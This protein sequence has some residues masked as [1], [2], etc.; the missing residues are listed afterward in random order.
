MN[1]QDYNVLIVDDDLSFSESLKEAIT[2]SGFR[3][4]CVN[5]P[6]D[7][8]EYSKI[9]DIHAA[10]IDCLLP[11]INGLDLVKDLQK[12]F[13]GDPH[14][15]LMSGIFK[16][17]QFI[18]ESMKNIGAKDFLIK[19]FNVRK[20]TKTLQLLFTGLE[21]T[22]D[23]FSP[24]VHLYLQRI[25]N[26][27]ELIKL[28]NNSKGL[29][30]FDLPW[31]FKLIVD[32]NI[33]GHLSIHLTNGHKASVGFSQGEIVKVNI[34][35]KDSLLGLLL[36]EK[37]YLDREDLDKVVS[38]HTDN[39]MIGRHLIEENLV[40]PH[41]ISIVLKDQLVWRLKQLMDKSQMEL[42]FEEAQTITTITTIEK[43]EFTNFLLD[44]IKNT[45]SPSWLKTHY[46]P[47]S[48]KMI[49]IN[50]DSNDE[51]EK[52]L[53]FPYVSGFYPSISPFLNRGTTLE[54]LLS[55]N[56]DIEDHVLK[57]IHFL[58]IMGCINIKNNQ[59]HLNFIHQTKRLQKLENEFKH[60]N[61]FERLGVSQ[62][63]RE[64]D[65]KKAYF[66]LAKVLHPDRLSKSTPVEVKEL[67]EKVFDNIQTAYDTLRDNK[68][69]EAYVEELESKRMKKYV[70]AEHMLES[71]KNLFSKGQYS[72]AKMQIQ[73]AM[74]LNPNSQEIKIHQLWANIKTTKNPGESFI[75]DI[76]K[77]LNL[78]P[79][80]S[81]DSASYYY[82]RGLYHKLKN[83]PEKAKKQFLTALS[84]DPSFINARREMSQLK[85]KM[86]LGDLL[87]GD[88]KDV[89][90]LLFKK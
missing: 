35:S 46:L 82:V 55:Q 86:E 79:L 16:D 32:S 74:K 19:P 29:H 43:N 18:N 11:K 64:G 67:S 87:K 71:A 9:Q 24:L 63:A 26:K 81:R 33:S 88:I 38:N 52:I 53:T 20:L 51:M 90:G 28:I 89:V 58:N 85:K 50:S 70:E 13:M 78:I 77:K 45:I 4:Y 37:G 14:I 42:N 25:H 30:S 60:K 47:I 66:D 59:E 80:E 8:L 49:H 17:E 68:K 39:K 69:R 62:S 76:N 12:N 1:Y 22:G 41:A 5:K 21:E 48:Q 36:V 44:T 2:R 34:Q 40:S 57:L 23:N 7:A 61:Y 27:K 3:C 54:E 72:Q 6:E 10:L 65:V 56:P 15:F 83:D 75:S 31:I 73:N 84:I